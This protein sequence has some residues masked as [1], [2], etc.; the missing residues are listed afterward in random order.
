MFTPDVCLRL[1]TDVLFAMVYMFV[2]FSVLSS[3][4]T[5]LRQ[6]YLFD[7]SHISTFNSSPGSQIHLINFDVVLEDKR[8]IRFES[9]SSGNRLDVR[10]SANSAVIS[11]ISAK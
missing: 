3:L 4:L 10:T 6:N 8:F 1:F 7:F 5:P 11:G 9:G 2:C